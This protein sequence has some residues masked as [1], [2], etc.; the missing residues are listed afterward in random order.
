[1]R[2]RGWLCAA[3]M[4]PSIKFRPFSQIHAKTPTPTFITFFTCSSLTPVAAGPSLKL[5]FPTGGTNTHAHLLWMSNLFVYLTCAGPNP[6]LESYW[7]YLSAAITNHQ[8]MVANVLLMWYMLLG[9][10]VKEETLWAVDKSYA[11]VSLS[12][13]SSHS[14]FVSQ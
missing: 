13:L 9:G 5:N 6:I 1:M 2:G 8:P 12:L 4:L 14:T 3:G 10:H 11:V 7:S